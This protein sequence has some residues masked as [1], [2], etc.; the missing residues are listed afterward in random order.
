[1]DME[2]TDSIDGLETQLHHFMEMG[3]WQRASETIHG[4]LAKQPESA[5]NHYWAGR[6]Y[7]HLDN[8]SVA[9]NHLKKCIAEQPDMASAYTLLCQVH[10]SMNRAGTA[11]D[12]I[13]KSL[14]LDPTSDSAWCL[15]AHLC[16]H[17][18]NYEAAIESAERA[19]SLDPENTT[20]K[21]VIIRTRQE[22]NTEGKFNSQEA[23]KAQEDLLSEDPEND[24]LHYAMGN[25]YYESK[26]YSKAE[27]FFRKAIQLAPED[28]DY[29]QSLIR[30]LRK[31]DIVLRL[32]WIPYFP[33]WFALTYIEKVGKVFEQNLSFKSVAVF[34]L[35]LPLILAIKYIAIIAIVSATLFFTIFWPVCKVYEYLTIADI[36]KKMGLLKLYTGPMAKIHQ[37]PFPAR[38][39]I[40]IACMILFWGSIIML[41]I[42]SHA[43]ALLA[44][45]TSLAGVFFLVLVIASFT[46]SARQDRK[47]KK[48]DNFLNQNQ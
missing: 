46:I 31:R 40:F 28:K 20:A 9:E 32:L 43:A 37:L 10:L 47:K 45:L 26:N 27:E 4:L 11:D 16:L 38:L 17:Y 8:H 19:I 30:T 44:M 6:I 13:K 3:Q 2:H 14:E 39:G 33:I 22:M 23:I 41:A 15:H 21:E 18:E 29:H 12:Y 42:N 34:I 36:H 25:L 1:M 35:C 5:W 7:Y 48:T 24:Y